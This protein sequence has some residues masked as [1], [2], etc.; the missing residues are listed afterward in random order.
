[1]ALPRSDVVYDA[2]VHKSHTLFSGTTIMQTKNLGN[3][4]VYGLV[5]NTGFHT[6]KGKRMF[7]ST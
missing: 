1:M 5:T 7:Y 4:V 3:P 6:T 2:N